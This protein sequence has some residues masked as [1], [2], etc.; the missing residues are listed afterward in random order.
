MGTAKAR[1]T[2]T[3]MMGQAVL[4]SKSS[5]SPIV[6]HLQVFFISKSS[7]SQSLLI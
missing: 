7:S 4:I 3:A 5:S 1:V 2:L 6:L